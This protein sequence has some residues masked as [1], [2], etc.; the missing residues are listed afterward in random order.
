MTGHK[1]DNGKPPVCRGLLA[2]FPR[3]LLAVTQVSDVGA[4]KYAW[5]D[6]F[7]VPEGEVRYSDALG[8]H[9]LQEQIMPADLETGCLHAA[10]IAWNA[11][12]RLEL[13]LL[14]KDKKCA[15]NKS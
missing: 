13:M 10:H 3:A 2:Y 14:A 1:Y 15:K 9:L 6:W 11:L 8:R 12:A 7:N 5:N 4:K